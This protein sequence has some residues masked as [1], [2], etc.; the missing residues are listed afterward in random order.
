MIKMQNNQKTY[1]SYLNS[2]QWTGLFY[3]FFF[4]Y[5]FFLAYLGKDNLDFG[6]GI[7]D[8]LRFANFFKKRIVGIDINQ[9]NIAHCR[10]RG[11]CVHKISKNYLSKLKKE[12][13]DTVILDNVL[14][15]I[16]NPHH[17][18]CTIKKIL[19]L[20]GYLIV[21]IPVGQAG[22]NADSDHKVYYD[23]QSLDR[24]LNDYAF[25]RVSD[26]YRPFK[27]NYLRKNLRQYCYFAIYKKIEK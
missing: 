27:N 25:F 8:F 16:L 17:E 22:Y 4:I 2:R 14:E 5:P 1:F 7:G 9:F 21:A 19:R 15:H 12:S 3:R 6:C 24:L 10:Q 11:F 18:L 26:F 20:N 23:E 13:F